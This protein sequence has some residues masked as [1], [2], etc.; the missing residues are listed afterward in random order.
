MTLDQ[1]TIVDTIN[2]LGKIK[3]SCET[4]TWQYDIP[5]LSLLPALLM[6]I[7]CLTIVDT[8]CFKSKVILSWLRLLP[9]NLDSVQSPEVGSSFV[10]PSLTCLILS[11]FHNTIFASLTITLH[12]EI[13][14]SSRTKSEM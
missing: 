2:K 1:L 14:Q 8:S 10:S 6:L 11:L 7:D 5:S 4:I 12:L 3:I 9:V 13:L